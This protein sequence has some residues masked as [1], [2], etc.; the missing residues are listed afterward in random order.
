MRLFESGRLPW[1]AAGRFH[2][3]VA[4]QNSVRW[5][6]SWARTDPNS[7]KAS[8]SRR[9]AVVGYACCT[10]R[11]RTKE[12]VRWN[13]KV[14]F[15][16]GKSVMAVIDH[17]EDHGPRGRRDAQSRTIARLKCFRNLELS[18]G[19]ALLL[20]LVSTGV[21]LV[22]LNPNEMRPGNQH[23]LRAYARLKLLLD[24]CFHCRIHLAKKHHV[25]INFH[26][27]KSTLSGVRNI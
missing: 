7:D 1:P 12:L 19:L 22:V 20:A 26:R 21:I 18:A 5:V 27:P 17:A 2:F 25:T 14:V 3:C 24:G 23:S 9:A 4:R 13:S 16:S 15:N 11:N 10:G 6:F 8:P